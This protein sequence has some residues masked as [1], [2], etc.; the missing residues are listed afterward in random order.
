MIN[1][2]ALKRTK[3]RILNAVTSE[4]SEWKANDLTIFITRVQD[5]VE[6]LLHELH[7]LYSDQPDWYFYAEK[8]ILEAGLS[9]KKRPKYL[10]EVDAERIENPTWFASHKMVGAVCYVDL[11]AGNLDG[12][13][14]KL[15]Y[16]KELGVTYLHLMPLFDRPHPESDGGYAVSSYRKVE[17]SLGTMAG[18]KKLSKKF[19]KEGIS[20]VVDFV[21]NHT[22]DEHEWAKKAKAGDPFYKD[23]YF[24]FP[25]KTIPNQYE[26]N[27]REI[28]PE[29]RRGS[30]HQN[31]ETGEWVWSTFHNFQ[32]DLN[33]RNPEVLIAIAKEMLFLAN[34]GI[35]VLR[36]D[37]VPFTWKQMGTNCE[38]L[39]QAHALI[40]AL[41]AAARMAAPALTFKSEAIV[42]PDDVA[43]YVDQEECQLSYNPTVMALIWESMATREVKLLKKSIENR[44]YI[45]EDCAWVNYVRS[46]DDIGWTFSDDDAQG[47]GIFP[48]GH[49]FFLNH[50]YAKEFSGSFAKGQP[51]QYNPTNGDLRVCGTTASL[52]GLEQAI[53]LHDKGR[54]KDAINRII[55]LYSIAL[56]I[57]GIPLIYLG[58][59]IGLMN[60]YSY[61]QDPSKK[62]DTRWV[63]RVAMDWGKVQ[64]AKKG[65]GI[66]G[67]IF[68]ALKHRIQFRK[69]HAALGNNKVDLVETHNDHVLG[70]IKQNENEKLVI[71]QN[72]SESEQ[73][74]RC[75]MSVGVDVLTGNHVDLDGSIVLSGYQGMW[76]K[77]D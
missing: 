54:E 65:Q 22:S 12:I 25:D 51:F 43:K 47:L 9:W 62:E 52:A 8:M 27:L 38:N 56:T 24:F 30:F 69:E 53:E 55:A 36:L 70:F 5:H 6:K 16:F 35:D 73:E 20:L 34:Q 68:Q 41:N 39:P 67:A 48:E 21:N 32:W 45:P 1:E 19:R 23:F 11:F 76:V 7:F 75:W 2:K 14:E 15:P 77:L 31:K 72:F 37:A 40:R 3:Q 50:F 59:E 74:I 33:Y 29:I 28:F 61:E 4:F 49:R 18:L 57:G 26:Q 64:T 60:D 10:R 13:E 46:H 58:D 66:E 44:F 42:H 17:P 71:I 63:H